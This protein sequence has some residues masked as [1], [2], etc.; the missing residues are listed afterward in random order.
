MALEGTIYGTT[1]NSRIKPRLTWSAVQNT[2]ENYSDITVTLSYSRTNTG[3]KT[4]GDW[5]GSITLGDQRVTGEKHL[6]ITYQSNTVAMTETFRV[7]HDSYGA[8]TV[9]V[10]ATGKMKNADST[11]QS[12]KLSGQIAPDTILRASAVSCGSGYIGDRVTVVVSRKNDA[13]THSLGYRFGSL[14]GWIDPE[15][16]AADGEVKLSETAVNFLLPESF[17]GQIPNSP[18]QVCTLICSTYHGDT[19]IG[20]RQTEFTVTADPNRCAPLLT[21]TARDINPDTLA[22]TGDETLL[23]R[24][25]SRAVCRVAA[26]AQKGAHLAGIYA[27]EQPVEGEEHL[28]EPVELDRMQFA[29]VDTRGYATVFSLEYPLISYVP[30]TVNAE[31]QRTDP[32]GG[33]AVLT[34]QGNCWHGEFPLTE[35]TLQAVYRVGEESC[36]V[37]LTVGEDHTYRAEILLTG[38]DYRQSHPVEVTVSDAAMTVTQSLTVH[39]G[40]PVFHWGE[41]DFQF[42]VPVDM[43]ALS[44]DGISLADYIRSIIKES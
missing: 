21:V 38:L 15:G 3:Y 41:G 35:N 5:T 9:Q 1:S 43:P 27:Q 12:T 37:P 19:C 44:V 4:M 25:C 7:Y 13:F 42:H 20:Q 26:Q 39:K 40:L 34:L 36:T 28:L 14:S 18:S 8:L 10:S 23:V 32:T 31:V 33:D 29:A 11:L 22:L 2:E 30:L 17:Y 6:T 16:Q 24:Y